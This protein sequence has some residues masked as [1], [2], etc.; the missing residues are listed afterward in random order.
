MVLIE[1]AVWVKNETTSAAPAKT[2]HHPH[3]SKPHYPSD[4]SLLVPPN[5]G[6]MKKGF[7]IG[8]SYVEGRFF[9]SIVVGASTLFVSRFDCPSVAVRMAFLLRTYHHHQH[10][11]SI[12]KTGPGQRTALVGR[13]NA[14]SRIPCCCWDGNACFNIPSAR[15]RDCV[16]RCL[17]VRVE[18]SLELSIWIFAMLSAG[19]LAPLVYVMLARTERYLFSHIYKKRMRDSKWHS[20]CCR[21]H[22]R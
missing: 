13:R 22:C 11:D 2:Y 9:R 15:V 8:I 4:R 14:S 16:W 3:S 17:V 18:A 1:H 6:C 19:R 12:R 5:T 20:S 7:F 21:R 10:Q